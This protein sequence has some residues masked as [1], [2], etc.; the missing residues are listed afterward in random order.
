[1]KVMDDSHKRR[2]AGAPGEEE[3]ENPPEAPAVGGLLSRPIHDHELLLRP[4]RL[5]LQ[6]RALGPRP[7]LDGALVLLALVLVGYNNLATE[8]PAGGRLWD[9]PACW[10]SPCLRARSW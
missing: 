2:Q 4:L 6:V 5:V 10:F 8:L 1:M 3:E 7:P 9:F